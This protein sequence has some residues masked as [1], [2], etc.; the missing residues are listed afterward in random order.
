MIALLLPKTDVREKSSSWRHMFMIPDVGKGGKGLS[1]EEKNRLYH[2][3]L[4]IGLEQLVHLQQ[5]PPT[6]DVRVG[7]YKKRMRVHFVISLILG[8]Q[9]SSDKIC[10]RMPSHKNAVRLHRGCLTS[11]LHSSDASHSCTWVDPNHIKRLV[12][13]IIEG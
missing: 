6:M 10:A 8:D 3:G 5:N 12:K 7:G 2:E 4:R 13:F 1:S 9:E 11:A